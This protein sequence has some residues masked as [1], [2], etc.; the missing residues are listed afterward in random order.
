MKMKMN[1]NTEEF[2]IIG[3]SYIKLIQSLPNNEKNEVAHACHLSIKRE[4]EERTRKFLDEN[5]ANTEADCYIHYL[6]LKRDLLRVVEKVDEVVKSVLTFDFTNPNDPRN[7]IKKCSNC[8]EIWNKVEG[9]DGETT[10]GNR[11]TTGDFTGKPLKRIIISFVSG[12]ASWK[13]DYEAPRLVQHSKEASSLPATGKQTKAKGCGA[14]MIWSSEPILSEAEFREFSTM[15]VAISDYM[16]DSD[17]IKDTV[18]PLLDEKK[19]RYK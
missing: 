13:L 10:C 1:R 15:G 18:T 7:L 5:P 3:D 17:E 4:A 2:K 16:A 12:I 9:C 19:N 8:G 14:K 11:P 6:Q